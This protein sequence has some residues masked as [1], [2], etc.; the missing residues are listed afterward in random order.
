MPT[1]KVIARLFLYAGALYSQQ[2]LAH[3]FDSMDPL[4]EGVHA[5]LAVSGAY[6]T[7]GL[8]KNGETWTV[9]GTLMGGEA[10]PF[11]AGLALD[12]VFLTPIYRREQTYAMMKIGKHAGAGELEL[13]H[14]LV[15]HHLSENVAFEG[16][17]MAAIFT[18]FNGEHP[19][20]LSFSSRRL[21]YDVLWGG[22]FNGEGV[23]VKTRFF[24]LDFGAEAWRGHSFPA[25][26]RGMNRP[27]FDLYGRYG[28]SG[29]VMKFQA[30][31]FFFDSRSQARDDDR[32]GGSHSHSTGTAVATDPTY[33][34]GNE[35]ISGA[36]GK[37]AWDSQESFRAGVQGEL[38]R[39]VSDGRLRDATREASFENATVGYWGEAFLGY[40]DGTLSVRSER[41]K[42]NN[43]I[44]GNAAAALSQKLGFLA[45]RKDPYRHTLSYQHAF[46]EHYRM[47]AEWIRDLTTLQRKDVFVVSAVWSG[48]VFH[49][50]P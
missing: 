1:F 17:K 3:A 41:L 12:E 28:L 21:V 5:H 15:G 40:E 2:A 8:V 49:F 26:Q 32:S 13:D 34:Y 39:A 50:T 42:V 46:G 18:P 20:D 22:Q 47:R 29:A 33:F 31:G 23:R 16:G 14:A 6:R 7:K 4:P 24:G 37:L 10:F 19:S 30:G 48:L 45:S 27:A 35:R 36:F 38:S 25:H 9:P 43:T 11:E 44:R